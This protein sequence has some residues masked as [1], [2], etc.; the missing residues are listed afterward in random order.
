M[1]KVDYKEYEGKYDEGFKEL[2]EKSP[3]SID[4]ETM[5]GILYGF[6]FTDDYKKGNLP[7]EL[8]MEYWSDKYMDDMFSGELSNDDDEESES[9]GEMP[10]GDEPSFGSMKEMLKRL[11][12]GEE[13][14]A[15]DEDGDYDTDTPQETLLLKTIDST[16][17]GKTPETAL[18]VI[19]VSQEYE[20]I[21][22]VFPYS[23][24]Q[25]VGQSY[26]KGVDCLEF[27]D[28]AFGVKQIYFDIRR[29][30]EVGYY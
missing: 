15:D 18:C 10:D 5:R 28:N 27:A 22:R 12:A 23:M 25:I 4:V 13:V 9:G 6:T 26:G 16:G 21:S 1:K 3:E 20:Y 24:L 17:D 11:A 14:V 7:D 29:R 2:M 8:S 19:D 30:F